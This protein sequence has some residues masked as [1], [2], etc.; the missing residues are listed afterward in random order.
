MATEKELYFVHAISAI[1]EEILQSDTSDSR[2]EYA[3]L[4]KESFDNVYDV[5]MKL[6]SMRGQEY[7]PSEGTFVLWDGRRHQLEDATGHPLAE[8]YRILGVSL[9]DSISHHEISQEKSWEAEEFKGEEAT[10]VKSFHV[11]VGHGNCSIIIYQHKSCYR[12]W[13]VDC[14]VRDF[15]K[16][17]HKDYSKNLQQCLDYLQK[18]YQIEKISKLLI[19]HRHYDHYNGVAYLVDHGYID[20]DTEVWLNRD[21]PCTSSA[22]YA[23]VLAK[24]LLVHTS[25]ITPIAGNSVQNT[26]EVI[27]PLKNFDMT[28]QPPWNKINNASVVYKISL[29]GASM[30]FPGDIETVGWNQVDCEPYLNSATYYCISHHGSDNGHR[31][32]KCR[33]GKSISSLAQCA[34]STKR[35]ILMG[36]NGAFSGIFSPTVLS[37]FPNLVQTDQRGLHYIELDWA[38]GGIILH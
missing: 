28:T 18:T 1:N 16:K 5:K 12:A 2:E 32:N 23:H 36:R 24:L 14:S 37:A 11:N 33:R 31:R 20:H 10:D 35:Q 22:T 26:I 6:I 4:L 13:M 25:F 38:T 15:T 3:V 27:Y 30:I 7:R 8:T 9:N 34:C 21:Y 19:T 29:G 17:S